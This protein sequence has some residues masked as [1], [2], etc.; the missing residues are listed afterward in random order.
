MPQWKA[1]EFDEDIFEPSKSKE[2]RLFT[3]NINQARK[4][5][6]YF[7]QHTTAHPVSIPI[8]E[9]LHQTANFL[10]STNVNSPFLEIRNQNT[11]DSDSMEI[12]R[13]I[14]KAIDTAQKALATYEIES[15]NYRLL[16]AA[17]HFCCECIM[18]DLQELK[19]TNDPL[20]E[21]YWKASSIQDALGNLGYRLDN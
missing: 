4:M 7:N 1:Q 18:R 9:L 15:S 8:I 2:F 17:I 11:S 3:Y 16:N 21:K 5:I 14:T 12:V 10:A 6:D 20:Y 19:Q 13:A